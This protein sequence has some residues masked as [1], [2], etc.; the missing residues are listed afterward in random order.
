M[1]HTKDAQNPVGN[2]KRQDEFDRAEWVG[3]GN[4]ENE[5][6]LVPNSEREEKK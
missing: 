3:C 4:P 5:R 1:E 6:T 2:R